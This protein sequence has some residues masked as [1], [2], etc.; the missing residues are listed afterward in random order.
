MYFQMPGVTTLKRRHS[1]VGKNMMPILK[2]LKSFRGDKVTSCARIKSATPTE[3]LAQNELCKQF[4]DLTG[5]DE[6]EM[7]EMAGREINDNNL[8]LL[9]HFSIIYANE[10][11]HPEGQDMQTVSFLRFLF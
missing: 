5:E 1:L 8:R 2:K 9:L 7:L 10:N 6:K 11:G 3:E 4:R